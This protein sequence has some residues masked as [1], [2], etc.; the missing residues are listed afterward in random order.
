[1]EASIKPYN[2]IEWQKEFSG[3]EIYANLIAKYDDVYF[4]RFP[5]CGTPRQTWAVSRTSAIPFYYIEWIQSC[6]PQKV[7]DLGCGWNFFKQY[8]PNIVGIDSQLPENVN[9]RADIHAYRS[10]EHTV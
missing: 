1:M 2:S 5:D 6:K 9:Y 3:T 7:Y 10:E 4:E 8:Y